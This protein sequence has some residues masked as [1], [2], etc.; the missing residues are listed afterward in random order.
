MIPTIIM[1]GGRASR[2]NYIEKAIIKICG[3]T[4]LERVFEAVSDVSNEIYVTITEYTP[5]TKLFCIEKGLKI[6]ETSGKGFIEDSK[7]AMDKI[8]AN[9]SLIVCC[10]LPFLCSLTL[11]EFI[12]GWIKSFKKAAAIYTTANYLKRIGLYVEG[13]EN[14][15]PVGVNI[16]PNGNEYFEEYMH[17]IKSID[18]LNVNSE[19]ELKFAREICSKQK[20]NSYHLP[21]SF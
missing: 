3:K 10:D 12:E 14:Y 19:Y 16:M 9:Y 1:A 2:M 21:K 5:K 4:M 11:K 18:V 7:E 15:I 20:Q 13:N 17:I 8:N 6:L